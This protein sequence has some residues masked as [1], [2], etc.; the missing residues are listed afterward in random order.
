MELNLIEFPS[1]KF[2]WNVHL[3][4]DG[5]PRVA[6]VYGYPEGAVFDNAV[7]NF[8]NDLE[9]DRAELLLSRFIMSCL[10]LWQET[11]VLTTRQT[12]LVTN[13]LVRPDCCFTWTEHGCVP[14]HAC[15]NKELR[16]AH[17]IEKMYRAKDFDPSDGISLWGMPTPDD[18]QGQKSGIAD[19]IGRTGVFAMAG[20][21]LPAVVKNGPEASAEDTVKTAVQKRIQAGLSE[22]VAPYQFSG[23]SMSIWGIFGVGPMFNI[24]CGKCG[25]SFR[26][27]LPL[28][29]KP[30]ILCDTCGCLNEIPVYTGDREERPV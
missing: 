12:C 30:K 6:L 19:I 10:S 27:R 18:I 22:I 11:A 28:L 4:K 23:R 21:G 25:T 13:D 17:N 24:T 16:A 2:D 1:G 29:D 3:M 7:N 9:F 20:L 8:G 15:T 14:F 26:K 5:M